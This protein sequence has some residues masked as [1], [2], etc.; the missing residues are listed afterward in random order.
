VPAGPA[1]VASVPATKRPRNGS[2]V[3]FVARVI[4]LR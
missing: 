1:M 4:R 3:V 2:G